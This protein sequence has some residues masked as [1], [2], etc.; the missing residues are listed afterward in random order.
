MNLILLQIYDHNHITGIT[1][2]LFLLHYC[3][4]CHIAYAEMTPF[5]LFI[6]IIIPVLSHHFLINSTM[7]IQL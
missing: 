5:L 4:L 3:D 2:F 1:L 7:L 6:T